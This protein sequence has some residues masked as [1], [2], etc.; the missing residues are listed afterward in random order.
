MPYRLLKAYSTT[1]ALSFGTSRGYTENWAR[2]AVLITSKATVDTVNELSKT[3]PER[4]V[5]KA[6]IGRILR[7]VLWTIHNGGA[8][9][10]RSWD[11]WGDVE[12]RS[13]ECSL[14]SKWLKSKDII[15][16]S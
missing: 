11:M 7:G 13:L 2:D 14:S 12:D 5:Q 1:E 6:M 3:Y 16:I 8:P 4:L 10:T 9:G 15:Y